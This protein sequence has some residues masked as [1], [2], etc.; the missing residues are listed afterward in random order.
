MEVFH[1]PL[2]PR[3]WLHLIIPALAMAVVTATDLEPLEDLSPRV[4]CGGMQNPENAG[5]HGSGKNYCIR[6]ALLA[7]STV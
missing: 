3:K 4:D 2:N 1:Y 5:E 6:G 7:A